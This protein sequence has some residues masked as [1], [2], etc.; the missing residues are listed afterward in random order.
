MVD[1]TFHVAQRSRRTDHPSMTS[2]RQVQGSSD[3]G[4][5]VWFH[6]FGCKANQYDTERMRQELESRG[7]LTVEDVADA[8]TAVLNTCTVTE[9]ADR[10]AM[11]LVRRLGRRYPALRVVVVGC[12]SA[13]RA[14]EYEALEQV[15]GVVEGH[16]PSA[17]ALAVAPE[18]ALISRHEEPIGGALLRSNRRGTR[19]WL[20]IQDG[21]DRKCSFCATRLA[22][23]D[24][25][26]RAPE[27]IIAEAQILA[28]AHSELVLTGIHIGHYGHDLGPARTLSGLAALLLEALPG[29]RFRIG[30]IEATEIDDALVDLL[31]ESDGALAPHLHVPLQ[32]G[33]D[34]VLRRMRRWHSRDQYR[35]R[36]LEIAERVSPLGL[37]ADVIAGFPGETP[38]DQDATRELIEELPFTYLHVFPWSPRSGTH[39][40][41]LPDRV[42]VG[43]A[44]ARARE[45][46][47]IGVRKG[48]AYATTRIGGAALVAVE[49]P[50]SGLT[51]DYLRVRLRGP[52][53][54]PGTLR[55]YRLAGTATDL[56]AGS[57]ATGRAALPVLEATAPGS[58]G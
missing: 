18:S 38:E 53:A 46:R 1:A 35:A 11:R 23:G 41:T 26:S 3:P 56:K 36:V 47:E 16:D 58:D 52:D 15:D 39:A 51:G 13:L 44:A 40:A 21:C 8:D 33:S 7:A 24:S 30:S 10:E 57:G 49:T 22:R 4:A 25:R 2:K 9:E 6:T 55:S 32:S 27:E 20:K 12:S 54:V 48:T 14:T 45:L 19:G 50:S 31:A 29:V 17:V 37:G 34:P 43:T 28:E 5:A 42:D